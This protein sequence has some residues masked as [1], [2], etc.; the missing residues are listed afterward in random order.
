MFRLRS[1]RS[2]LNLWEQSSYENTETFPNQALIIRPKNFY[3]EFPTL[4]WPRA[5]P[6]LTLCHEILVKFLFC[7]S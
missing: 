4:F 2:E 7:L 6:E 5:M 3:T 1:H